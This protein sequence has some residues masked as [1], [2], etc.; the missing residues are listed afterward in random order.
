MIIRYRNPRSQ[1]KHDH[2][3][4]LEARAYESRGYYIDA[5]I[6]GYLKPEIVYGYRPDLK[7]QKGS[8]VC[9]VEVE[10]P[11]FEDIQIALN[12]NSITLTP[13]TITIEAKKTSK[14][15][16]F[17]VHCISQEAVE[18]TIKSGG[19]VKRIQDCFKLEAK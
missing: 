19:F 6:S 10:T 11:L 13:G 8:Y 2:R 16:R 12:A 5:D 9:I 4:A 1:S 15:S 17:L 18:S 3:V 7:V 14:G